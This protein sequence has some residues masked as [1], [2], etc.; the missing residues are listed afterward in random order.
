MKA[1]LPILEQN[2]NMKVM[3]QTDQEQILNYFR[4]NLGSKCFNIE[5]LP[6]TS[7]TKG[8]HKLITNDKLSFGMNMLAAVII[9]SRCKYLI[10]HTGN[11]AYWTL[12]YR[13]NFNN[14]TQF[15]V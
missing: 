3:V 6:V 9:M 2:P 11:V 13:G 12:L 7:G 15:Y 5:E 4:K 1:L 8:I 10:T 14:V